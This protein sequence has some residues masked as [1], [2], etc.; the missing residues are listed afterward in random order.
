MYTPILPRVMKVRTQC[1]N[2]T[3]HTG[4]LTGDTVEFS[5]RLQE[6]H[7]KIREFIHTKVIP[8]EQQATEYHDSPDTKW[9]V[10]PKIEELKVRFTC[11]IIRVL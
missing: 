9:T 8:L 4:L 10:Y 2:V 6:L 1:Y 7:S 11:I 5:P 3:S